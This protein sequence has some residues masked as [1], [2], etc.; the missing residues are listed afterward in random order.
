VEV[1]IGHTE[2]ER[3][4]VF[5]ISVE[6]GDEC[7]GGFVGELAVGQH[8]FADIFEESGCGRVESGGRVGRCEV[9]G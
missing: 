2:D 3:G 1:E 8:E 5:R 9:G 4:F 6:R 7:L